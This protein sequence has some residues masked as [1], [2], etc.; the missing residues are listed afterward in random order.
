[1]HCRK[2]FGTRVVDDVEVLDQIIAGQILPFGEMPRVPVA[3]RK[4]VLSVRDGDLHRRA[5]LPVEAGHGRLLPFLGDPPVRLTKKGG[6]GNVHFP[7][8]A[9]R[10]PLDVFRSEHGAQPAA[11]ETPPRVGLDAGKP[12][13][14]LTRGSDGH[15]TGAGRRVLQD[16]SLRLGGIPSSQRFRATKGDA[17]LVDLQNRRGH[18]ISPRV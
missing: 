6:V 15:R 10:N 4:A 5:V 11:A 18:R 12:D 9:K 3:G 8:P 17:P 16:E 14:I 13:E 2:Q 1:M 7:G